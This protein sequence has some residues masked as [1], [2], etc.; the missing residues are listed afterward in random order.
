MENTMPKGVAE[1]VGTFTLAFIGGA[2][3]INGQAGL[4]GVALAGV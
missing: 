4:I 3:I 1:L 2:A